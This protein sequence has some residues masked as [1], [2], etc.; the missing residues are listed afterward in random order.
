MTISGKS[1]LRK[2]LFTVVDAGYHRT[3]SA[4]LR[5]LLLPL[6][7]ARACKQIVHDNEPG[8]CGAFSNLACGVTIVAPGRRRIPRLC[9]RTDESCSA[10]LEAGVEHQDALT[11]MPLANPN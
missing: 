4:K 8:H 9:G 5:A 6:L 11:T 7:C 1:A 2:N 10:V 3:S